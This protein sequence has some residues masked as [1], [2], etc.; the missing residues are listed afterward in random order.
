MSRRSQSRVRA[1]LLR[2]LGPV[3]QRLPP[4]M[5]ARDAARERHRGPGHVG[6]HLVQNTDE[7]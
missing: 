6:Q 4:N 5:A 1:V 2:T 3:R 7:H